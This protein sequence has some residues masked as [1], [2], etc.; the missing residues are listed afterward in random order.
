M[1]RPGKPGIRLNLVSD[2]L[3]QYETAAGCKQQQRRGLGHNGSGIYV[4]ESAETEIET[5]IQRVGAPWGDRRASF[6][7][8]DRGYAVVIPVFKRSHPL[9]LARTVQHCR[10]RIPGSDRNVKT[11]EG[12]EIC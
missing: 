1:G 11:R 5:W 8:A 9:R 3:Q 2:L 12:N 4:Y 10:E 7:E 6:E